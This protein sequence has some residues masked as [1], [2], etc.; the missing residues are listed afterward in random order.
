ME[1]S[2]GEGSR[3]RCF[4]SSFQQAVAYHIV[5]VLQPGIVTFA[6]G[7]LGPHTTQ[8][9]TSSVRTWR[10]E[11]VASAPR[12]YGPANRDTERV[13]IRLEPSDDISRPVP[14]GDLHM[15]SVGY[16]RFQVCSR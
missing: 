1:L 16:L 6:P 12:V 5:A 15:H 11:P 7:L 4:L 13:W 10:P 14:V 9:L 2:F 3:P 8:Y